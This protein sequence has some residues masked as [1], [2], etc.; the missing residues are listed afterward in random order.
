[1]KLP[2]TYSRDN[3]GFTLVEILIG[4]A[5][6]LVLLG[7]GLFLS[8]D[9]YR[10]YAFRA[11]EKMLVSILHKARTRSLANIEQHEHGVKFTGSDF[12]IFEGQAPLTYASR[13]AS[14]DEVFPANSAVN[15][16]WPAPSEIVFDQVTGNVDSAFLTGDVILSG[17]GKIATIS[18]N[19]EGR[20]D[21]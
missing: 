9:F 2:N 17:Q 14:L 12:V 15:V 10:G 3:R 11:E 4:L 20:I 8:M 1:M 6:L 13:I 16:I 5:I 19:N 21:Y 7:M 18:S